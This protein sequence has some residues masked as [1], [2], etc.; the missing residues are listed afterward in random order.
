MP[1]TVPPGVP[2]TFAGSTQPVSAGPG[3]RVIMAIGSARK[4]PDVPMRLSAD[5]IGQYYGSFNETASLSHTLPGLVYFASGQQPPTGAAAVDFL[6]C[7]AGVTRGT[8]AV[9]DTNSTPRTCFTLAGIGVYAGTASAN[10]GFTY[11][12]G[13]PA[14]I[15]IVDNS[16]GAILGVFTD[17]VNADLSTNQKVV[18][19]ING[20]NLTNN[21]SSYVT[22]QMGSLSAT[23]PAPVAAGGT[24][25]TGGADGKGVAWGSATIGTNGSGG[26]LDQSIDFP[27]NFVVAGFDAAV[28]A[29]AL[30]A[31]VGASGAASADHDSFRE[32]VLGPALGT[33]LSALTGGYTTPF[34]SSRFACDAHDAWM[35]LH[36][37]KGYVDMVDGFYHA[38][39]SAGMKAAAPFYE[40][41]A[42]R[43][44]FFNLFTDI[45][46]PNGGTG[47][48]LSPTDRNNLAGA[49]LF[50]ST[51]DKNTGGIRIREFVTTTP[52]MNPQTNQVNVFYQLNRQ[53]QDD[54]VATVV[55]AA[56]QDFLESPSF[57]PQAQAT[58]ME[59]AVRD[60]LASLGSG[61]NGVNL[62]SFTYS[63]SQNQLSGVVSYIG[64]DGV[65]SVP[66]TVQSTES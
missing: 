20:V 13:P 14:Q 9:V 1:A 35:A 53:D 11:T 24:Q 22:A 6:M 8:Y 7:R 4:G 41:C 25:F 63:I 29:P 26:L 48:A 16:T 40:T 54:T 61:I 50:V 36:P 51:K 62:V 52:K 34:Q 3:A 27:V 18:T 28:C 64:R 47:P 56:L 23:A 58:L 43:N 30:L 12:A 37:A 57:L 49:G 55:T 19:A 33:P 10:L 44:F 5:Q 65:G 32:C 21:I 2:V 42:G 17:G 31:H 15:T 60:A 66:I 59:N 46:L 45:G 39:A 38:A